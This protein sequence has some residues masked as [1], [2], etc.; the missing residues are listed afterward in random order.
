M[1]L[2][3]WAYTRPG[4]GLDDRAV[5]NR[6]LRGAE[7]EVAGE[8]PA[9]ADVLEFVEVGVGVVLEGAV[10]F[11]NRIPLGLPTKKWKGDRE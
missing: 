11:L 9:I 10:E 1:G 4:A 8:G 5:L 7:A 3:L 2:T 6:G